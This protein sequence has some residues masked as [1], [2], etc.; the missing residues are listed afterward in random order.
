VSLVRDM[1]SLA[2]AKV[3]LKKYPEAEAL[4][5]EA[6]VALGKTGI[7]P[8]HQAYADVGEVFVTV[9]LKSG[10]PDEART[11]ADSAVATFKGKPAIQAKFEKL[12]SLAAGQ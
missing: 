11:M 7:A 1:T 5:K 8:D 9:L 6:T 12:R 4:L 3:G 2:Q 10:R